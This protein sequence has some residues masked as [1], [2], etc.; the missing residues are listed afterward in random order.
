LNG[1][2]SR[3]GISL[4]PC[5]K[6]YPVKIFILDGYRSFGYSGQMTEAGK[7]VLPSLRFPGNSARQ[8]APHFQ[9][10]YLEKASF[11]ARPDKEY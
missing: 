11:F 10:F 4:A 6:R 2:F 9:K 3:D 5:W 7:L 8:T 1:R